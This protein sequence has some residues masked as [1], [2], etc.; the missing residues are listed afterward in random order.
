MIEPLARTWG[1]GQNGLPLSVFEGDELVM[2]GPG[3]HADVDKIDE[4]AN[5]IQQS[6]QDQDNFELRGL[7]GE[8][9]L[10]GHTPLHDALMDFSVRWSD[11]LD[12]LTGDAREIGDALSRVSKAYRA[13]NEATAR[14]LPTDPGLGAVDDG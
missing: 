2:D 3:W 1:S 10:Y 14:S 6:V 4:A 12:T 13:V 8:P 11:G 7:C 5:G 9:E